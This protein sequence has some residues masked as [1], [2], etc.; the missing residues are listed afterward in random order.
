MSTANAIHGNR[1]TTKWGIAS[2]H[3]TS[4]SQRPVPG[5]SS[6]SSRSGYA[7]EAGGG[8]GGAGG[9]AGGDGH[10]GGGRR[11]PRAAARPE[12]DH[13]RADGQQHQATRQQADAEL[14]QDLDLH[15]ELRSAAT[16]GAAA[17]F[18]TTR[19]QRPP[20]RFH[21]SIRRPAP[22]ARATQK[23]RSAGGPGTRVPG[24]AR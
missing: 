6:P 21:S 11:R 15:A 2:S 16:P 22:L 17:A 13:R 4:H 5:S 10:A 7:G 19:L 24:C 14:Q 8:A 9:D 20:S 12:D 18:I 3:L 1:S 23:A